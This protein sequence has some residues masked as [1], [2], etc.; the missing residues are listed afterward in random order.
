MFDI[1]K[2]ALDPAKYPQLQYLALGCRTFSFARKLDSCLNLSNIPILSV[3]ELELMG[4]KNVEL[5]RKA[6]FLFPNVSSLTVQ[7]V[8][9]PMGFES[10]AV[11]SNVDFYI[12]YPYFTRLCDTWSLT[13]LKVQHCQLKWLVLALRHIPIE[14][15]QGINY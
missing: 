11:M 15:K 7:T 6:Q 1:G 3:T 5:L 14:S 13:R 10:L 2:E 9:I 12:F 8:I 4:S